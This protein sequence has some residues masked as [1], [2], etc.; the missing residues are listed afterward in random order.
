[1]LFTL[2][3]LLEFNT[4]WPQTTRADYQK[5][6]TTSDLEGLRKEKRDFVDAASAFRWS[7][8]RSAIHSL[9]GIWS[10]RSGF[11]NRMLEE[12]AFLVPSTRRLSPGVLNVALEVPEVEH[13]VGT[14]GFEMSLMEIR[15]CL[16]FSQWVK[17]VVSCCTCLLAS[18]V[19]PR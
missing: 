5:G 11:P 12:W 1:M 19:A 15:V 6:I 9:S 14:K 10:L 8:Y 18:K 7:R 16:W 4:I 3:Y 13:L 17:P 2:S